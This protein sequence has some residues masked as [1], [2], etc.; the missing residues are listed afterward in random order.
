MLQGVAAECFLSSPECYA[1]RNW[2]TMRTKFEA[3]FFKPAE[4]SHALL[5]QLT[6]MKKESHEPMR[7][8]MAKFNKLIQKIPEIAEP[9][10]ENQ[11]CFFINAQPPD[12]KLFIKKVG[13]PRFGYCSVNSY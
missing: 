2:S 8:F 3:R 4:D 6:H 9:T 5:A 11:K 13:Y 12:I 1:I 7:E 10:L